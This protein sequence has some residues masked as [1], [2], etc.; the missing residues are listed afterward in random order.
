MRNECFLDTNVLIYAASTRTD[1]PRKFGIARQLIAKTE[2]CLSG[3]VIAEFVANLTKRFIAPRDEIAWWLDR[4]TKFP[5]TPVDLDLV[6]AGMAISERYKISYW[7]GAIVAAA[8]RLGA[9]TLYTED[10]NDGQTY[11]SVRVV[12]PFKMH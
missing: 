2:F 5:V 4:L 3:Q 12:N 9:P 7:D 6:K 10:L 11:G 1:N 8:D